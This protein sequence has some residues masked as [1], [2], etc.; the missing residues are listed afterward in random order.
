M[1]QKAKVLL[2]TIPHKGHCVGRATIKSMKLPLIT[3]AA[4]SSLAYYYH[5]DQLIGRVHHQRN[6]DSKQ[7]LFL[8]FV[9]QQNK[10]MSVVYVAYFSCFDI[11]P[12]DFAFITHCFVFIVTGFVCSSSLLN[13]I[14]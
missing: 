13:Q 8:Y 11:F 3:A 4:N 12:I 1:K 7:S 2:V 6:H 14:V 9:N 5:Q 10:K